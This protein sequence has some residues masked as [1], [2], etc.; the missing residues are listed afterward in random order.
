MEGSR[1]TVP[2]AFSWSREEDIVVIV[3]VLSVRIEVVK[4]IKSVCLRGGSFL[5]GR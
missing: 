5:L 2:V 3:S 4:K 1:L